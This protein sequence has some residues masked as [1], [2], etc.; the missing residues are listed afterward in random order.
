MLPLLKQGRDSVII[1]PIDSR[2]HRGD[3]V[4][5][6]RKGGQ[7]ILHRIVKVCKN[8][9]F[10]MRGDNHIASERGVKKAQIVGVAKEIYRKD[11]R[12]SANSPRFLLYKI[13]WVNAPFIKKLWRLAG[14]A[15]R[16]FRT[17]WRESE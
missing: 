15:K 2:L 1:S 3:I 4:L 13:F 14:R 17:L 10:V 9:T 5:Y 16:K 8:G 11:K 7:Y 6:K 12:I